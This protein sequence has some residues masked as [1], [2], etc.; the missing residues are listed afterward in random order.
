M[1]EGECDLVQDVTGVS[2][3]CSWLTEKPALPRSR[4]AQYPSTTPL[5]WQQTGPH[6]NR[7]AH[8]Q[9]GHMRLLEGVGFPHH[10][11]HLSRWFAP[12]TSTGW[13]II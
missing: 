4:T 1:I 5:T 13:N 6:C 11:L 3:R 8:V 7:Q 2:V 12:E 10:P 9:G